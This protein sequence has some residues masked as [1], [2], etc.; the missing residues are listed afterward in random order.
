MTKERLRMLPNKVT[1][2]KAAFSSFRL[3]A[4][5]VLNQ[6]LLFENKIEET[7]LVHCK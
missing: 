1:L 6:I 7:I 5:T 4:I 3:Q 2:S